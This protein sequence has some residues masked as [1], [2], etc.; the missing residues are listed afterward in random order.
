MS[1]L[2]VAV[3]GATGAVGRVMRD[4]LAER[5]F[6]VGELRLMASERS[7]GTVLSTGF[8]GIEVEDLATADPTG[9]DIALFSAGGDRSREYAPKFAE[10]GAIVVDNS[11]AFRMDPE[12]PLVVADVNNE[13]AFKHNGIIANPN[14]T[15]MVL[16]MAVAPLHRAAGLEGMV[17]M[18]YQSVSGTGNS[19]ITELREQVDW[20]AKTPRALIDGGWEEPNHTVF[21]RPIGW[22][23]LAFAGNE[24]E[25]GYTDEEM[26]L[27]NE[28]RKILDVPNLLVEPTCVRVPTVVGH[29]IAASLWFRDPVTP[30]QAAKLIDEAPGVQV[31]ADKTAT[32]LDSAGIDD[33]LVSRI[34]PTLGE[35]GGISL[36][37]VGDNLR[38]GAAL[39]TIQIAELFL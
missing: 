5:S 31:W 38:K 3:V 4:I 23:V 26:K 20:F 24:V 35:S 7:A 2:T 15:T 30:E 19:A 17:A 21:T 12:V 1:D 36:W 22:N 25:N 27:Q 32:P 18:S 33:V 10:A 39:N 29:G 14:C 8:G 16:M 34:R 28:S 6:P 13:D 9:V 11:S 37:A